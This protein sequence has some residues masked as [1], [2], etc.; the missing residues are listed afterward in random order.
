[1]GS[2]GPGRGGHRGRVGRAK[3]DASAFSAG[4]RGMK[5]PYATGV[6]ARRLRR[7][8][9]PERRRRGAPAGG[10]AGAGWRWGAANGAGPADR[11]RVPDRVLGPDVVVAVEHVRRVDAAL[12]LRRAARTSRAGYAWRSRASPSSA[13]K[14]EYTPVAP[15][16]QLRL[17]GLG[18]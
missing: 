2:R 7:M 17:V 15:S 9:D 14:F 18:P 11:A 4:A 1:M 8:P 13:R 10:A 16:E 3:H 12:D 5:L 6:R